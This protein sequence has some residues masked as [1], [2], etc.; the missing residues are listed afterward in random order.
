MNKAYSCTVEVKAESSMRGV[1]FLE[2]SSVSYVNVT[3]TFSTLND[4]TQRTLNTRMDTWA[5]GAF[6]HKTEWFHRWDQSEFGGAYT[7]CIVLRARNDRLYG[8]VCHP[9][10]PIDPRYWFCV[11][12]LHA[13]KHQWAT[14]VTE[15]KRAKAMSGDKSVAEAVQRLFPKK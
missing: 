9:K 1:G 8:F 10:E 2:H 13:K 4:N 12:V 15:L 5:T 6:D 3:T 11:L 14:D 7:D